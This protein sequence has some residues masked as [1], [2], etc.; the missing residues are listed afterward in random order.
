LGEFDG[1]CVRGK[2]ALPKLKPGKKDLLPQVRDASALYFHGYA[3]KRF[4]RA[5]PVKPEKGGST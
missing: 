1:G 5:R 2:P 3:Q 4:G